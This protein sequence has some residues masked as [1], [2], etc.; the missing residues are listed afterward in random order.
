[1]TKI[2]YIWRELENDDSS[3]AGIIYKRYSISVIS[4]VFVAIRAPEKL[5]CIA[6]RI[7]KGNSP[8]VVKWNKL[9]DIKVEIIDDD[10]NP[11]KCYLLILILNLQHK[12]IFSVLC[13]DL[14]SQVASIVVEN[15]LIKELLN[16]LTKWQ[17]LFEKLAQ[18]G[19]SPESQRGLFGELYFLRKFLSINTENDKCIN[20]WQGPSNSA[21]DF[22]YG[23]WALEVKTTHGNNHQKIQI[24][25]ERQLDIHNLDNLILYHLSLESR[26]HSG[27]TLNQ[28][29]DSIYEFLGSDYSSLNC[30]KLKLFEAGYFDQHRH[31]YENTGYFIR[32]DIYYKV[33]NHFPRIEE[34]DI[35][36]GVGDVKYSIIVSLCQN[37]NIYE[38]EVFQ[39]ISFL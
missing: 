24:S 38:T 27:E 29:V 4:D 31:L 21:Q 35:R 10:S 9:K 1:M 39:I 16:R 12:D 7:L 6:A 19:L 20:S 32:Q 2:D 17:T 30:F 36:D 37:Y 22:Q 13:E 18:P 3:H 14:I 15:T 5:R 8:D 28:I 34:S 11:A 25:S 33:E 26:L 23:S